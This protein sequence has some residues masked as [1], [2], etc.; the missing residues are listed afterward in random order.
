MSGPRLVA[1]LL[2]ALLLAGCTGDDA[3]PADD[4]AAPPP[5]GSGGP[6]RG[7]PQPAPQAT[8]VSE[9]GDVSGPFE[10]AWTI[11]VPSVGARGL[12]VD[13]NLTGAQAGAPPTARVE[14][15]LL[16]PDGAVLETAVAGLG[17]AADAVHWRLGPSAVAQP[18]DYVLQ[19]KAAPGDL[20]SGG[21]ARYSLYAA[22][23]S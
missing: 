7:A 23:E 3:P 20:P 19:A 21:L 2:A 18:G 13:F 15:T 10:G 12:V 8:P 11:V 14:L 16:G 6:S 1:L 9:S 17:G 22:V 5:G 4:G